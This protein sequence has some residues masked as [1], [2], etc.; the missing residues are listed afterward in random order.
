MAGEGG[1]CQKEDWAGA[2]EMGEE[3]QEKVASLE[4][5][6]GDGG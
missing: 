5:R 6:E 1:L 4:Q 2:M 3:V